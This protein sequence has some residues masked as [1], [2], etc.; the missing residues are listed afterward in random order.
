VNELNE[1]RIEERVKG[2]RN[3][4]IYTYTTIGRKKIFVRF[5]L[6]RTWLPAPYVECT[7]YRLLYNVHIRSHKKRK[8]YNNMLFQ[9]KVQPNRP[10]DIEQTQQSCDVKNDYNNYKLF[11]VNNEA[12]TCRTKP[13]CMIP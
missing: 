12:T 5:R 13:S 4:R 1:G 6:I 11:E 7:V 8:Q 10:P 2:D 9:R 3:D